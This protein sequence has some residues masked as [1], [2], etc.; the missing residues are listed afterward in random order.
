MRHPT[1]MLAAV[2]LAAL[3]AA[4]RAQDKDKIC[5]DLQQ[6]PMTLGEW[7]SYAWTGGRSDGTTMR[8]AIV[9]TEA[10]GGATYY[11]YEMTI[12]DPKQG[13]KGKTIIQML[14]PGLGYLSGGLRGMIMKS[15]DAPATRMPDQMVQ[16]MGGRMASNIA[17]EM[18]RR[19]QEMEFVGW[20][21]VTVPAGAFRAIHIRDPKDQTEA[22]VR[23]ELYFGMVK[24]VMKDGTMVLTAHGG[25]A[26]SAITETPRPMMGPGGGQ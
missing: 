20:E 23:P 4:A 17:A 11:W 8:F 26:K 10:Q 14:V 6:R 9:G 12:V 24:V 1:F 22:W 5:R 3:P 16:M 18:T 2:L 21:N 7:A 25:G 15:G 19:C 13:A